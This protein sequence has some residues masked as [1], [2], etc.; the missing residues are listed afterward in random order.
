LETDTDEKLKSDKNR[1]LGR[2]ARTNRKEETKRTR[3]RKKG[4]GK[5]SK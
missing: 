5:E 1:D 4:D 2:T 3:T